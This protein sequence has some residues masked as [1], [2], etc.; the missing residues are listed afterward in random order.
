MTGEK[1][2]LIRD[3]LFKGNNKVMGDA[4]GVSDVKIGL[5]CRNQ[6]TFAVQSI[7]MLLIDYKI[8]PYWFFRGEAGTEV[9]FAQE[10][11]IEKKYYSAVEKLSTLQE[12]LVGYQKKEIA[13][14]KN[15]DSDEPTA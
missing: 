7:E 13:E 1:C 6:Q 15:M 11:A 10:S 14:L 4:L 2:V 12:E 3:R 8:D 9:V 5:I